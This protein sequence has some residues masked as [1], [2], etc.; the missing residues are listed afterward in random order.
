MSREPPRIAGVGVVCAAGEGVEALASAM[1]GPT[2]VGLITRFAL[3]GV[4]PVR[5]A[6]LDDPEA[7]IA[8]QRALLRWAEAAAR[9]A[10][11]DRALPSRAALVLGSN[12][13]DDPASLHALAAELRD[14][15]GLGGPALATSTACASGLAALDHAAALLDHG[16]ADVVI[17]GG[18]DVIT[19]RVAAGFAG[20]GIT[21]AEACAPFSERL[22][23]SLGEGAAFFVL[24]PA[25]IAPAD[26]PA[27]LGAGL[28]ADAWH[29][30]QPAPDGRGVE[31]AAR[32]ALRD[33][34]VSPEEIDHVNAHA[35]GTEA[36]DAAELRGLRRALGAEPPISGCKGLLGHAQGAAGALELAMSLL[37]RREGAVPPTWG[38]T[39]PR[40][41]APRD[42]VPGDAPRPGPH[43]TLLLTNSAFGGANVA[44]VVG[45]A[46]PRPAARRLGVRVAACGRARWPVEAVPRLDPASVDRTAALAAAA[47]HELLAAG[48]PLGR[49]SRAQAGLA[50][51]QARV[52]R[53]STVALQRSVAEGG[54]GRV[55]AGAFARSVLV[56][57][58][59]ALSA[60]LGLRGPLDVLVGDAASVALACV[61]AARWVE[62]G[63]AGWA[64]GGGV[65]G[66]GSPELAALFRFAEHGP[67]EVIA[68]AIDADAARALDRIGAS[69]SPVAGPEAA[70][71]ALLGGAEEVAWCVEAEAIVVAGLWRRAGDRSGDGMG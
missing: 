36:N 53:G 11:G 54:L 26:A 60:W 56:A 59:G 31:A 3:E 39:A 43:R 66:D 45:E 9:E 38:F 50:W 14:R 12:L 4:A 29:P 17:A 62:E 65:H 24:V 64:L 23:L 22:G 10:I 20:L 40:V 1:R 18:A 5:A 21:S 48:P 2:R 69:A 55:S 58:A 44:A 46:R 41:G 70:W 32:A 15:L 68:Q 16:D 8:P 67:V 19:A 63:R 52:D 34:G 28:A 33:A 37:A 51:G 13:E 35:T 47:A 57:P 71:D 42:P 27:W 49:A 7:A 61:R 25:A 30:T 6:L